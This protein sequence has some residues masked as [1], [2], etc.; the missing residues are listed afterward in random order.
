MAIAEPLATLDPT[1]PRIAAIAA[2]RGMDERAVAAAAGVSLATARRWLRGTQLPTL[3]AAVRLAAA[4]AVPVHTLAPTPPQA[5]REGL[6][7]LSG[8]TRARQGWSVSKVRDYLRCPAYFYFRHVAEVP[9]PPRADPIL[10]HAVH[11]VLLPG[12]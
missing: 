3:P 7:A 2:A 6:A 8:A 4:L 10:G 11:R 12:L 1:L 9:E 5:A